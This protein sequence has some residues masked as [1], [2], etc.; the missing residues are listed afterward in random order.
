MRE[1]IKACIA[2]EIA[3]MSRDELL[4]RTAAITRISRKLRERFPQMK[5]EQRRQAAAQL[6]H[7]AIIKRS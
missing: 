2:E 7:K 1:K 4:D 5:R 3:V 6:V